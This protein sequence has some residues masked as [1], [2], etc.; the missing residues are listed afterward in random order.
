MIS[1]NDV[2]CKCLIHN[3]WIEQT[4]FVKRDWN[5][6]DEEKRSG[7]W[8]TEAGNITLDARSLLGYLY[9]RI[10]SGYY[11][12]DDELYKKLWANTPYDFVKR[13]QEML[14][15]ICELNAYIVLK[16]R[17]KIDPTIDLEEVTE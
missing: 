4:I 15:E 9:D 8:T 2:D 1:I 10:E 14:D 7:Y 12:D 6:M 3:E 16:K 13:F 11:Y 17:E 5:S